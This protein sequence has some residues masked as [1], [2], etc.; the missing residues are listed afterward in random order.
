MFSKMNQRARQVCKEMLHARGYIVC[1]DTHSGLVSKYRQDGK[2]RLVYTY[3][4]EDTN[5]NIKTAKKYFML[6]KSND[7]THSILVYSGN[8]T[9]SARSAFDSFYDV[10]I[11]L[12]SADVLQ[13]NI[14]KH[15]LVPKHEKVK[16]SKGID[17][18]KFPSM[19]LS[20]PVS[21]FYGFQQGD[22]VRIHRNDGSIGFRVVR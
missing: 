9:P 19:K 1:S 4:V 14:T 10:R 6:I 12:F 16:R 11:E 13:F 21:R 15:A 22:L 3:F 2:W 7:I 8:M 5:M 20:D 18:T 17:Y